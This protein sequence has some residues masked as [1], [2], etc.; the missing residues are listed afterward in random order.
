MRYAVIS[1][2][3]LAWGV[4]IAQ[5]QPVVRLTVSPESVA[6]GEAAQ[7][8]VTVLVPTWFPKPPEFPSFEL[9]NAVTQLPPNSSHPTSERVGRETWS[10]I[11]RNYRVYPLLN[12]SYRLGG[13]TMRITYANP[14]ANPTA[15]DVTVPEATLRATVPAGAES[16]DPYV[17]GRKLTLTREID[18]DLDNLE[19]GDAVVIRTVAELDGLPAM[20][21]PPVSPEMA[22]DGVSTYADEPVVEDGDIARRTETV[23]MVFEAGGDFMLPPIELR[24]WDMGSE[25]IRTASV[26]AQPISVA[27][28]V[29]AQARPAGRDEVDWR[30]LVPQFAALLIVL[31]VAGY[32]LRHIMRHARE[33]AAAR[34]ASE[35]FAFRAFRNAC[36][37]G[38]AKATHLALVKWLD[39]I[40]WHHDARRFALQYG[41]ESLVR[42][43][44][45]LGAHLYGACGAPAD[46]TELMK[47]VEVARRC[48]QAR[49][50]AASASA[51]PS[52]N[53]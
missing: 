2:I 28:P 51:L 23:T 7:M 22:F 47:G 27:G 52:L 10:G 49:T 9:N 30:N 16:L 42:E 46:L 40:G 53:P 19:A 4:A 44:D 31:V 8:R 38:D 26:P 33:Q 20:F 5:E 6:V 24:W 1:I 25:K 50:L 3:T 43:L 32:L 36:R 12:A 35:P 15:V 18:G 29:A 39:R 11:T 17:A 45:A 13:Q 37:I 41:D 48:H 21:L 14:G 34:R